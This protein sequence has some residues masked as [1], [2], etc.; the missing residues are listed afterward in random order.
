M[1][2]SE[3]SEPRHWRNLRQLQRNG[4]ILASGGGR[5]GHVELEITGKG[6]TALARMLPAWRPAQDKVVAIFGKQRWSCI[7]GDL[8]VVSTRLKGSLQQ[9]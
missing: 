7:V 8:E 4:L 5:G 2:G 6:R 1:N 3:W 9:E